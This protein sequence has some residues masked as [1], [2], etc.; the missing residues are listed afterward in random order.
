MSGYDQIWE[1]H[2]NTQQNRALHYLVGF[3]R[4]TLL[5][6]IVPPVGMELGIAE[7]RDVGVALVHEP[8]VYLV[9]R[10]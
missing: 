9:K 3:S 7:E 2:Q 4:P 5:C 1:C 10:L 8:A 6:Q